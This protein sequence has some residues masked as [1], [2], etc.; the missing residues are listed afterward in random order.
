VKEV[1]PAHNVTIQSPADGGTLST[2]PI[3][4]RGTA[5][6]F[7]NHVG[8]RLRDARGALIHQTF[9]TAAGDL[10]EF[11]PWRTEVLLTRWPGETLTIEAFEE[12]AKDGSIRS[13]DTATL[14][15]AAEKRSA[16]LHFARAEDCEATIAVARDYPA[17]Q[18]VARAVVEALLAGPTES[19]KAEGAIAPFPAGTAVTS[20]NLRDGVL[21]VDFNEAMGNVGGSCRALALRA[22]LETSLGSLRGVTKVRLTVKGREE[23]ALQP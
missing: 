14:R 22:M 13:I 18:S 1:E 23:I 2:N 20:I 10:G 16:T 6:T 11:N 8:I 4:I 3:V 21:T 17:T 12:S 7:E 19:E 9:A 5:R 15:V